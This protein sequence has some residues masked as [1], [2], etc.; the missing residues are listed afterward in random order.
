MKGQAPF[1]RCTLDKRVCTVF[2]CMLLCTASGQNASKCIRF[3]N[4]YDG[5][6][7]DNIHLNCNG[8]GDLPICCAAVSKRDPLREPRGVGYEAILQSRMDLDPV[9]PM[10]NRLGCNMTRTYISSAYEK[11][12]FELAKVFY[13]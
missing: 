1:S 10:D 4:N 9:R 3:K 2:L 7:A 13:L 12:Q 5:V 8:R 6:E 11:K